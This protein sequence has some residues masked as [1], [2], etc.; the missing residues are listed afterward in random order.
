MIPKGKLGHRERAQVNL[1]RF[2]PRRIRKSAKTTH[3]RKDV[4]AGATGMVARRSRK[5]GEKQRG[6]GFKSK[7]IEVVTTKA[8]IDTANTRKTSG[9]P[10]YSFKIL[11]VRSRHGCAGSAKSAHRTPYADIVYPATV[12]YPPVVVS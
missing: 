11:T 3:F 5:S 6:A 4:L 9:D 8:G 10:V 12:A 7:G 2:N 1:R